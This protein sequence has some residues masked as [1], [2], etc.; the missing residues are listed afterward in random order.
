M[1]ETKIKKHIMSCFDKH[2]YIKLKYDIIGY[3]NVSVER[4]IQHLYDEYGEKTEK[5]QNKALEDLEADYDMTTQSIKHLR[6][7]Q[8]KLKLFLHNTEQRIPEE[9]YVKKTF[10]SNRKLQLHQQGRP[11]MEK[12]S[13][14]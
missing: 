12:T 9:I 3:T 11:Q 6:I 10:G 8:E 7:R 4:F 13:T 1:I 2:I 5:L 14:C